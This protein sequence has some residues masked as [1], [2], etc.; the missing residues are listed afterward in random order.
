MAELIGV[1]SRARDFKKDLMLFDRLLVRSA[2]V[3][4]SHPQLGTLSSDLSSQEADLQTLLDRGIVFSPPGTE[5]PAEQIGPEA[6]EIAELMRRDVGTFIK[7]VNRLR[8]FPAID[9]KNFREGSHFSETH[10]RI[11]DHIAR[12]DAVRH[13][14]FDG[15]NAVAI[16]EGSS[17]PPDQPVT[18]GD[19]IQIVLKSLPGPSHTHRLED[20]L[21]FRDETARLRLGLREWIN[22]MAKRRANGGGSLR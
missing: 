17:L 4:V 16:T 18:R 7:E 20:I 1:A 15:L 22:E 2:S 5:V 21:G 10:R 13:R 19:V 12:Y 14:K 9:L 8:D 3:R 11:F 6:V